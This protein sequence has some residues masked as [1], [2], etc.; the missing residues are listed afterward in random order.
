MDVGSLVVFAVFIGLMYF[1]LIR[2]QRKRQ[3]EQEEMISSLNRGDDVITIGGLHGR[4]QALTEE[5]VDLEVTDDVVL[6]FQ[7]SSIS[8]NVSYDAQSQSES[9]SQ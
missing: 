1:L 3:K 8:R 7:K 5:V 2:P 9:Q 6:R 4:I